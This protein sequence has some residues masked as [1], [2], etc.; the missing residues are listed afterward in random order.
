VLNFRL[1]SA[2]RLGLLVKWRSYRVASLKYA[3]RMVGWSEFLKV[4]RYQEPGRRKLA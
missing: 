4:N 2:Y 1:H 3:A